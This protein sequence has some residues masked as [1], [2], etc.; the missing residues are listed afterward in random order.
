ME[1]T[2]RIAELAAQVQFHTTKVDQY[3][4]SNGLPGPSFGEDGPVN[5]AIENDEVEESRLKALESSLELHDLLIGPAMCLR[6]VVSKVKQKR[7]ILRS[8]SQFQSS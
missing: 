3:L 6:P 5:V 7:S 4:H 1:S 2:S 8:R